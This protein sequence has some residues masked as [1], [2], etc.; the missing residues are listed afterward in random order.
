MPVDHDGVVA[1]PR[2]VGAAGRRVAEHERD[3]RDP[4]SA[5]LGEVVEDPAGGHEQLALGRQVRAAGLDEVRPSG[6]G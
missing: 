5:Q 6:G 3:R 4:E 2:H 1:H